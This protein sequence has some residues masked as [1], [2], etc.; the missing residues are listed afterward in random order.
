MQM[1]KSCT[2]EREQ[3]G[4]HQHGQNTQRDEHGLPPENAQ[5]FYEI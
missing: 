4:N 3:G 5:I 1:K 2:A